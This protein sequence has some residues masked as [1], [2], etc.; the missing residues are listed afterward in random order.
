MRRPADWAL[1]GASDTALLLTMTNRKKVAVESCMCALMLCAVSFM[2][3][4]NRLNSAGI[5]F[6]LAAIA[7]AGLG[8]G[9]MMNSPCPLAA[10]PPD[11]DLNPPPLSPLLRSDV[12]QHLQ[13]P[14]TT[15]LP[16]AIPQAMLN[17]AD[18]GA[19]TM[20]L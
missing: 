1:P 5:F 6:V 4:W 17:P 2:S 8:F 7:V 16:E 3:F 11:A 19:E 20:E 13:L 15:E 10:L 12:L 14:E 18:G 9:H